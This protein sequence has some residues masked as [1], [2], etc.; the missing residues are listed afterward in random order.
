[1]YWE[2]STVMTIYSARHI[3]RCLSIHYTRNYFT[4]VK[5]KHHNDEALI[6]Y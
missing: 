1:M 6:Q 5:M 2:L 3:I 4:D